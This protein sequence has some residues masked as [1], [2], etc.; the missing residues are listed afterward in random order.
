MSKRP[1]HVRCSHNTKAGRPCRA[2]AVRGSD[3]PTCSFH[4]RSGA[5]ENARV[6]ARSSDLMAIL[7][8]ITQEP[9]GSGDL[10]HNFGEHTQEPG[11]S[12]QLRSGVGENS[13]EQA[14]SSDL[15]YD[16]GEQTREPGFYDRTLSDEEL[17]DLVIHAA[18]L[19]LDDEIACTRSVVRRT[20]EFL[21]QQPGA[22]SETEYLRAAGLVLQGTR[23]IARLLREQQA[24]SGGSDSRFQDIMDA[25][26]DGLSE[27]WGIEL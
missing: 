21:G 3:P 20:L 2:W 26:L 7:G 12:T 17:A 22:L 16:P 18:E 23:T 19:S 27:E 13:Q 1:A 25:A 8:E 5:G 10:R 6:Q 4:L 9:A 11:C 15:R 14:R 24:L